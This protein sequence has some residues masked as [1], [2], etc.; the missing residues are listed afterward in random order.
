MTLGERVVSGPECRQSC[1]LGFRNGLH[2]FQNGPLDALGA[3]GR[4]QGAIK[5]P[6]VLGVQRGQERINSDM[7]ICPGVCSRRGDVSKPLI[8]EQVLGVTASDS[9][10]EDTKHRKRT[11]AR[12]VDEV[13]L[14]VVL[15][16]VD[17]VL[18]WRVQVELDPRES[19]T[20]S[21]IESASHRSPSVVDLKGVALILED[22][23]SV[24]NI[25]IEL[26]ANIFRV[27]DVRGLDVDGTLL[28]SRAA[29]LIAVDAAP[30]SATLDVVPVGA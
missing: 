13:N 27:F 8:E 28:S 18:A 10:E 7:S 26:D 15:I 20:S 17:G 30:V 3:G 4:S 22:S 24:V 16:A 19:G 9:V 12:G 2:L 5:A 6:K 1:E 29:E 23:A 21:A 14:H 11:T 25:V